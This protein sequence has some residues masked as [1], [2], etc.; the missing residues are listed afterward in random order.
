MMAKTVVKLESSKDSK[1]YSL[2]KIR[3]SLSENNACYVLITCKE[4]TLEGKMDVEMSYEGDEVL[5]S[6]LV[7]NAQ[8]VFDDRAKSEKSH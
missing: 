8:Q 2:D 5:A 4:P 1:E 3:K 7:D 6:Y